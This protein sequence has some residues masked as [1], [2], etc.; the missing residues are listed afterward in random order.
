MLNF[1]NC[2]DYIDEMEIDHD[3]HCHELE[4][5]EHDLRQSFV[6]CIQD[7]HE[8]LFASFYL[9]G[10][11]EDL[12]YAAPRIFL[13]VGASV[14]ELAQ[15]KPFALGSGEIVQGLVV[16][17]NDV[18]SASYLMLDVINTAKTGTFDALLRAPGSV[19]AYFEEHSGYPMIL[20]WEMQ[21][22]MFL[23]S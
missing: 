9:N 20:D 22:G 21:D 1:V 18:G 7:A 2:E 15:L 3:A 8:A 16:S 11:V 6:S 19:R 23:M 12:L 13:R 10:A 4:L 5:D 17:A 14:Q